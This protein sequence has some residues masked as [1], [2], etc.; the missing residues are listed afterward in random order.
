[1]SETAT[2]P[3]LP[4]RAARLAAQWGETLTHSEALLDAREAIAQRPDIDLDYVRDT[5]ARTKTPTAAVIPNHVFITMAKE[6][7]RLRALEDDRIT[8]LETLAFDE[9]QRYDR[10]LQYPLRRIAEDCYLP[11]SGSSDSPVE[12]G[13]LTRE[14]ALARGWLPMH[15]DH[16]DARASQDG[17]VIYNRAGPSEKALTREALIEAYSSQEAHAA[18]R[19]TPDKVQPYTR[20]GGM[21]PA[22]GKWDDAYVEWVPWAP[23][24]QPDDLPEGWRDRFNA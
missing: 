13:L 24:D 3:G 10:T 21:N 11:W 8:L 6:T 9:A 16:A 12:T 22:T 4:T 14:E 17:D 19:L 15:L 1:M 7:A 5:L 23:D 2:R 20:G 18:F